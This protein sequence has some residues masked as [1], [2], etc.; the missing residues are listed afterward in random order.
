MHWIK[1]IILLIVAFIVGFLISQF[2]LTRLLMADTT[3]PNGDIIDVIGF[4][5]GDTLTASIYYNQLD[6]KV[7]VSY[8]YID[9]GSQKDEFK[10][11]QEPKDAR[12]VLAGKHAHVVLSYGNNGVIERHTTELPPD[13]PVYRPLCVNIYVPSV[14]K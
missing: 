8:D 10:I 6:W 14:E 2:V 12:L 7:Q 5:N 9:G 13:A 4:D 1:R 3:G 11:S